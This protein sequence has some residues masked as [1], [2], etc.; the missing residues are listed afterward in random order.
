MSNCTAGCPT[1]DHAT[2]GDCLRSKKPV[3]ANS[4]ATRDGMYAREKE[5]VQ[6]VSEYRAARSQ[7]IQ[8]A[9]S[10]LK[11]IRLAVTASQQAD[12]ALTVRN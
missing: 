3:S 6:I 7:G 4:T 9:T 1:Q 11:D 8:P 10:Q 2:Y 5:N 12:R